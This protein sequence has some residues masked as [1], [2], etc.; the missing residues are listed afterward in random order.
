MLSALIDQGL[1]YSI[2]FR[3]K[4]FEII[5]LTDLSPEVSDVGRGVAE[6]AL[7]GNCNIWW[8]ASL[9]QLQLF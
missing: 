6:L 4:S 9:P 8:L 3:M 1:K 2:D 5:Y 7:P